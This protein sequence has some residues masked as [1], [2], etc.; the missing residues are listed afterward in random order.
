[1]ML[2]EANL[3]LLQEVPI[4][5]DVQ[6]DQV[7][8]HLA[9]NLQEVEFPAQHQILK[10]GGTGGRL[11]ILTSGRVKIHSGTLQLLT[12]GPGSHFGELSLLDGEP[13]VASVTTLE[14]TQCWTL[15]QAQVLTAIAESPEI[16]VGLM[17]G[18]AAYI[19]KLDQYATGW[20][21]GLLSVAWAD[22][23]YS[24]QEKDLL[25]SLIHQQLFPEV[26]LGNLQPISPQE[27][28]Q[29]LG[30]EPAIAENFLRMAMIVALA[31][32]TYSESED[33][34]L[35]QFCTYLGLRPQVLDHLHKILENTTAPASPATSPLLGAPAQGVDVLHP[36]RQ[37]LDEL[38]V[39]TPHT[40]RFLCKLIPAQ[41]PFE[42]D[43]V[44]FGHKVVHIP[45]MCKL[46]PLYDQ[47]VGLRFRALTY[48]AD[49]CQEDITPYLT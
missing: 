29:C 23:E 37:W 45:P 48:L 42:R 33:R 32:G 18:L 24:A 15:N 19:R 11:Y 39:D 20:V 31:N 40:A 22:G 38:E 36:I 46:N 41:C 10:Q 25:E 21:R 16:G 3:Q 47:L 14:P 12:L 4:F 44:L 26:N 34:L 30:N 9:A 2:S 17:R 1:M 13:P 8:F 5:R 7:L 49:E 27:L 43:I 28:A 35:Q 6:R